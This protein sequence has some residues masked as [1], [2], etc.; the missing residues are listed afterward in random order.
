MWHYGKHIRFLE[1]RR[2]PERAKSRKDIGNWCNRC[3]RMLTHH[4]RETICTVR[5][6][7]T[8]HMQFW[9]KRNRPILRILI[10]MAGIRA[11]RIKRMP[12]GT[13]LS[14]EM[15]LWSGKFCSMWK[16]MMGR[17][18][19]L[20]VW[21]KGNTCGRQMRIFH[22]FCAVCINAVRSYWTG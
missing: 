8:T 13:R 16:I 9:W 18:W 5:R 7:L 11:R 3:I 21:L 17:F 19:E 10:M 4:C 14:M 12:R 15:H 2:E 6:K 20:S 22:F 1:F